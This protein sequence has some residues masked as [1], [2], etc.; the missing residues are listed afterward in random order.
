M[1]CNKVSS[2]RVAAA[3]DWTVLEHWPQQSG[4]DGSKGLEPTLTGIA[5]S[6]HCFALG[7]CEKENQ[8]DGDKV[9]HLAFLG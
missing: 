6:S 9:D 7:T 3:S 8:G 4:T 5:E 2:Y 1:L